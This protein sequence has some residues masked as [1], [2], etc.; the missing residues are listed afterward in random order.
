LRALGRPERALAGRNAG[1][2]PPNSRQIRGRPNKIDI[3]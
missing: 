2:D 3:G 1:V